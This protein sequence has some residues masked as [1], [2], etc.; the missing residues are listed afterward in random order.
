MSDPPTTWPNLAAVR[1]KIVAQFCSD[2]VEV[3]RSLL[4]FLQRT[5]VADNALVSGETAP[6]F[7]LPDPDGALISTEQLRRAGP[8]VVSFFCGSWCPFCIAELCAL[9]AALPAFRALNATLLA[10]SP[11]PSDYPRQL[12]AV[13]NLE[14]HVLFDR[15]CGVCLSYGVI[16]SLPTDIRSRLLARGIDLSAR[17]QSSDWMLPIPATFIIDRNGIIREAF[18]EPDLT[19]R[20]EPKQIVHRL[21]QIA[22]GPLAT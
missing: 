7:V 12:S 8:L 20:H 5:N 11:D 10:I 19:L 9:Q 18:V 17:Q 2:Q 4:S 13:H 3:Y 14:F 16:F 1:E 21:L 6:D 22:E 15:D